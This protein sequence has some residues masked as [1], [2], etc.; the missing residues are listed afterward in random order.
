ML[1]FVGMIIST[2]MGRH[3][4]PCYHS[5]KLPLE[6]PCFAPIVILSH[7]AY[8]SLSS[9]AAS[10]CFTRCDAICIT[11]LSHCALSLRTEFAMGCDL[12]HRRSH[13][14]SNKSQ[15]SICLI[16][17]LMFEFA[18]FLGTQRSRLRSSSCTLNS[19]LLHLKSSSAKDEKDSLEQ[20][21][22]WDSI[23][24]H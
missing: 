23:F 5:G 20:F 13:L 3:R 17:R 24:V 9:F 11:N 15:R 18:R 21:T 22:A 7:I 12:S 2:A 10:L 6:L 1:M 4:R 16:Q 14:L 8:S 19:Q